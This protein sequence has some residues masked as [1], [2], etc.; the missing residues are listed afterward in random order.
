[1]PRKD[2]ERV[3][4]IVYNLELIKG[5]SSTYEIETVRLSPDY[6]AVVP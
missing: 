1:M 3:E 6:C 5:T 4:H 2:A